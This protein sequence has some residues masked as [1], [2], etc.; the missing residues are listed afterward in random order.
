MLFEAVLCLWNYGYGMADRLLIVCV[1]LY[2]PEWMVIFLDLSLYP[3]IFKR[4][5]FHLFRG[6]GNETLTESELDEILS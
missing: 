3:M 4:K 5:S 6:V 1:F 2:F